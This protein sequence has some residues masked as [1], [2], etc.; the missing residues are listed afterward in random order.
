MVF[1][2]L[3]GIMFFVFIGLRYCDERSG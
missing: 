3:V 2:L 1:V